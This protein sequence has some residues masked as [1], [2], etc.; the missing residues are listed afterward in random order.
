MKRIVT[1]FLFSVALLFSAPTWAFEN[2][3]FSFNPDSVAANVQGGTTLDVSTLI[4]DQDISPDQLILLY[5][6][7]GLEGGLAPAG[8]RMIHT[9][10][11]RIY[12]AN[13]T[14]SAVDG[15]ALDWEGILFRRGEFKHE[16]VLVDPG[17]IAANTRGSI[18]VTFA[19][20]YD[21]TLKDTILIS[22]PNGIETSLAY[23]RHRMTATNTVR[24]Y[25]MNVSE[26]AVDGA[27]FT[28]DIYILRGWNQDALSWN[29]DSVAANARSSR[30]EAQTFQ[31]QN[32]PPSAAMVMYPSD[33][34]N[35]GLM[36]SGHDIRRNNT[37]R[38]QLGNATTG[39]IDDALQTWEF[40]W[41][42]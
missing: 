19:F 41:K 36:A 31:G 20:N 24:I 15:A 12:L 16:A 35:T 40:H 5:A 42:K 11:L 1:S 4:P 38:I 7:D 18:D 21:V 13:L 9:N 6:P 26:G 22:P 29:P 2:I 23:A 32:I 37:Y 17:S 33:S 30:T 27:S 3:A 10:N 28:W 25:I 39:A 14:G 8:N 34:L